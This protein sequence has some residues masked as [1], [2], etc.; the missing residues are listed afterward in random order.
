M[1]ETAEYTALVMRSILFV[2][3]VFNQL[4]NVVNTS[5]GGSLPH[6]FGSTNVKNRAVSALY[7]I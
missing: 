2:S 4:I 6:L 5:C 1:K 7:N 3:A